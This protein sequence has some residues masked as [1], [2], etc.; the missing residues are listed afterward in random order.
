MEDGEPWLVH[1]ASSDLPDYY[2]GGTVVKV[3]LAIYMERVEKFSGFMVTR[4]MQE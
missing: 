1:A 3:P 2:Q 4:F